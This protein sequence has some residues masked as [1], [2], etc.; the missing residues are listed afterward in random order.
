MPSE[1]QMGLRS[2]PVWKSS[3][4]KA[5]HGTL[6]PQCR[7]LV[8]AWLRPLAQ[9]VYMSLE[10]AKVSGPWLLLNASVQ[11]KTS[12][13]CYPLCTATADSW[14]PPLSMESFM[15]L[16]GRTMVLWHCAP[17]RD[18]MRWQIAGRLFHQCRPGGVAL[19]LSPFEEGYTPSAVAKLEGRQGSWPDLML[20]PIKLRAMR[21]LGGLLPRRLRP[22]RWHWGRSKDLIL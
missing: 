16:V 12:G 19:L 1:A 5:T 7:R 8:A 21:R 9:G 17:P 3:M 11:A 15:Q 18:S 2:P 13:R 6:C 20:Q 10:A 22:G 4:Q 14:P